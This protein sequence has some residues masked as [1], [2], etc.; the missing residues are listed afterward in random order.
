MAIE[1]YADTIIPGERRFAGD[2]VCA[3][4][5]AG[6]GAVAAGALE[7]L[8][9][10]AGGLAE[11]LGD[12]AV[13]LNV[14]AGEYAA[15]HDLTLDDDVPPFVALDF[16]HR[17]ALVRR[18]TDPGHPEKQIWIGLA[19]FSNMAYDSAAHMHTVDALAAG[20]PGLHAIGYATADVDGL[21]RFPRFSY[22]RQL[23]PLH[24]NTTSTG[25]PA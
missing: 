11:Q 18:L 12:I 13:L 21:W 3:G 19:L 10:S 24:P 17:T 14:H 20:H 7:L 25:S 15:E 5:A 22:G 16:A 8:T 23:A 6:G 2:R 1:A 4:A 9:W